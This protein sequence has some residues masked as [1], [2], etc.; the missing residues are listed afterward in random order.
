MH[1]YYFTDLQGIK[2]DDYKKDIIIIAAISK[3][4]IIGYKNK[5][6]WFIPKDLKRFKKLTYKNT[7]IMGKKTFESI[8]NKPLKNRLNII[9]TNNKNNYNN[10]NLN[11]KIKKTNKIF[12]IGGYSIYKMFLNMDIVNKMEITKI[13]K[14]FRGDVRFPKINFKKWKIIYEKFVYQNTNNPYKLVFRTYIKK[15]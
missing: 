6:P 11:E 4:N 14:N 7:I 2:L 8:N 12:I 10:F 3:N 1:T 15:Y 9:L 5:L 13:Y